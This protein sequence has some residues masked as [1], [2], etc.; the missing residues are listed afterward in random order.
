LTS[1]TRPRALTL[2]ANVVIELHRLGMWRK[3]C[4]ALQVTVGSIVASECR[5]FEDSDTGE[6]FDIDLEGQAQK[7]EIRIVEA[8]VSDLTS[9]SVLDKMTYDGLHDGEQEV[10]AIM[11]SGRVSGCVL[12]TG[13]GTALRGA[14]LGGCGDSCMSLEAVLGQL[15]MKYQAREQF[16]EATFTQWW[17]NAQEHRMHNIKL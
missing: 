14:V 8:S 17:R 2:D 1:H 16:S 15:R 13:D 3:F 5:Y 12:C 9:L 7:G 4:K 10:L 6:R 11:F